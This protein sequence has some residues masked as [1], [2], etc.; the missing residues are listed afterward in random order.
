MKGP[1]ATALRTHTCGELGKANVGEQVAVCGAIDRVIDDRTYLLRDHYGTLLVRRAPGAGDEDFAA[2]GIAS[3]SLETV[4]RATG[5]LEPRKPPD[6]NSPSGDV[7]VEASA[8]ELLA[9]PKEPL[10]FDPKYE[11]VPRRE[12]IRHRYRYLRS[13]QVHE[14][15]TF[16]TKVVQAAR[17]FLIGRGF[18]EIET[19]ILA[20]RWTAD[21]REC[22]LAIR[23]RNEIFALPGH[24][25]IHGTLLMASGFD[26]VFEIARRFRRKPTYGPMQQP[27]FDVLD[28]NAAYVDEKDLHRL[29]DE[30]IAHIL[31]K[32]CGLD[33]D[34]RLVPELSFEEALVR[35]GSDCPDTRYGIE[36]ADVTKLARDA[37]RNPLVRRGAGTPFV[38]G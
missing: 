27:E 24:R 21:A 28:I 32:E 10:L 35:Y 30:L 5:K 25:P 13:P 11:K 18:E 34:P 33:Q 14:T 15:F 7:Q 19:P 16:R 38:G 17:R 36:F 12:R 8:F 22:W 2:W 23:E 26:R 1:F 31:K 20:N 4:V 29:E 3:P 9:Y 6:P 37:S